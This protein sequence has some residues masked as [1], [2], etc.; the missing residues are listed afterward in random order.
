MRAPLDISAAKRLLG[1][2]PKWPI[3]DGIRQYADCFRTYVNNAGSHTPSGSLARPQS[4]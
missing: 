1:W 4:E 3:E 2:A